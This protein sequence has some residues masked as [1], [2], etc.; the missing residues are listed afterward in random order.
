MNFDTLTAH[1]FEMPKQDT[2]KLG[3][4]VG[5]YEASNSHGRKKDGKVDSLY[6]VVQKFSS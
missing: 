1:N 5:M 6:A 3:S 2:K 4:F